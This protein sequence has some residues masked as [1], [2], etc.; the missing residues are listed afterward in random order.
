MHLVLGRGWWRRLCSLD[1]LP[2]QPELHPTCEEP[3]SRV[4]SDI[5]FVQVDAAQVLN[6]RSAM[7]VDHSRHQSCI[8]LHFT[9]WKCQV[10]GDLAAFLMFFIFRDVWLTLQA[11]VCPF[12]DHPHT[13]IQEFRLLSALFNFIKRCLMQKSHDL[14][15]RCLEFRS[16]RSAFT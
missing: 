11:Q 10:Y 12:L 5:R 4:G 7:M 13:F 8:A 2:S 16:R 9:R 3:S 15:R 1:Y 14:L 6:C